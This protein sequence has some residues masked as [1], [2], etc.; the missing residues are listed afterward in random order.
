MLRRLKDI[1]D[2]SS[3]H[4]Q[5]LRARN[6]FFCAEDK[7]V[8]MR[9]AVS[10]FPNMFQE[11]LGVEESFRVE[12]ECRSLRLEILSLSLESDDV[13]LRR[14]ELKLGFQSTTEWGTTAKRDLCCVSLS[15][16]KISRSLED[17]FK[18]LEKSLTEKFWLG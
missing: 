15:L 5:E 7:M 9:V 4:S 1:Q 8:P 12:L 10:D 11:L 3:A 18:F 14:S 17:R 16:R 2:P 13:S 6:D